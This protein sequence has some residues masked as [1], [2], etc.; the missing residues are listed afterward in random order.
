MCVCV[1]ERLILQLKC[2]KCRHRGIKSVKICYKSNEQPSHFTV[3]L[4]VV[5]SPSRPPLSFL[6]FSHSKPVTWAPLLSCHGPSRGQRRW[7]WTW[8]WLPSTTSSTSEAAPSYVWRYLYRSTRSEGLE[9]T[10]SPP[11]N[12]AAF[13]CSWCNALLFETA[14]HIF[15]FLNVMSSSIKTRPIKTQPRC[16]DGKS[17]ICLNPHPGLMDTELLWLRNAL[18]TRRDIYGVQF[19]TSSI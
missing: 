14:H 18:S 13:I 9:W 6:F 15:F 2:V 11:N 16:A 19:L 12:Q 5:S 17:F 1:C 7:C 4:Q 8:R 10:A 3:H